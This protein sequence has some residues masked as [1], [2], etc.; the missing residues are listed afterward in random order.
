MGELLDQINA[1]GPDV[2]PLPEIGP[3]AE[4]LAALV[5]KHPKRW[6]FE[7]RRPELLDAARV[8]ARTAEFGTGRPPHFLEDVFVPYDELMRI[9]ERLEHGAP[10]PDQLEVAARALLVWCGYGPSMYLGPRAFLDAFQ[11]EVRER[12]A[13]NARNRELQEHCLLPGVAWEDDPY[14][15]LAAAMEEAERRT[16]A[17]SQ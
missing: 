5:A 10:S 15:V 16:A 3:A 1:G 11:R 17:Q 14:Q 2:I 6:G 13:F 12:A 8:V 7:L 4:R 9:S